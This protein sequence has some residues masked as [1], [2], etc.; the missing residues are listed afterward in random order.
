MRMGLGLVVLLGATGITAVVS[1][2]RASNENGSIDLSVQTTA[3]R[4]KKAALPAITNLS[5]FTQLLHMSSVLY[6]AGALLSAAQRAAN[7]RSME[8]VMDASS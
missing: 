1:W 5:Q 3:T 2:L 6:C 7:A 8:W 4:A